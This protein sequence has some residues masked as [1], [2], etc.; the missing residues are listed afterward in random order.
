MCLTPPAP[1][2]PD[3]PPADGRKPQPQAVAQG[4]TSGR[5]AAS[6]YGHYGAPYSSRSASFTYGDVI[7]SDLD[8]Q[9][10]MNNFAAVET[11]KNMC[12]LPPQNLD[13][14]D[15]VRA[16]YLFSVFFCVFGGH[17]A[18]GWGLWDQVRP[19]KQHV[20]KAPGRSANASAMHCIYRCTCACSALCCA[21]WGFAVW[22]CAELLEGWGRSSKGSSGAPSSAMYCHGLP[23]LWPSAPLRHWLCSAGARTTTA[24]A[25]WR[26]RSATWTRKR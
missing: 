24:T 3:A 9:R 6:A 14:W 23:P 4:P 17:M 18:T 19:P 15:Q 5:A 25:S 11:L 10:L 20:P 7:R 1:P 12:A 13:A 22:S 16:M 26:T 2:L 21:R 8:E